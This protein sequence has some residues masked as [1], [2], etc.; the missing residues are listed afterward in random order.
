[1]PRELILTAPRTLEL[2]EY[3][4]SPLKPS[5]VR[6]RSI[7]TAEKHGTTL[8]EYRGVTAFHN[9]RYDP[10]LGLFLKLKPGEKPS[11]R[12]PAR[13]GN[14]TVGVVVEV[15]EGV[16]RFKVGDR[17]Y[18][19]LPVR[20]THTVEESYEYIWHAPPELSD[21]E[22][23]CID[24]AVVALMGV[25]EGHVRLGDTVAVFG[26]G[27]IGLMT[28]QMA[29]L[30]G[31]LKVIAVEPIDLRRKLAERYGADHVINPR[32]CDPGLE[33]K[34][35]TNGRGVDVSIDTSGSYRALHQAIRCTAYGGKVVPVSWYHG[36]ALGLDLGEEWHFNRY[37]M[38]SGA[39]VESE[40]YRDHPRWYRARVYETVVELFRRRMLRVDGMLNPIVP[41]EEAVEAYRLID[42]H[43]EQTVK[44]AIKYG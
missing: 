44:L 26:L 14:M 9:K 35:L 3:E 17:V 43:P 1:M 6:V 2:R 15:G 33:V 19:Y 31:S 42:E 39:R 27:A 30:S 18:G 7:L 38:V 4:E 11:A 20:E 12:Y 41:L 5:Q 10:K 8:A 36:D 24:P 21:E 25:R 13:V 22:L 37:V 28:V 32:T 16:S 34:K 23:V 29:R 40:P